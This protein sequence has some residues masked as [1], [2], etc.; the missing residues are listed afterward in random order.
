[1][2]EFFVEIDSDRVDGDVIRDVL[3]RGGLRPDAISV[4]ETDDD[5]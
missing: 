4:Q 1:M 3:T 2:T 5:Q